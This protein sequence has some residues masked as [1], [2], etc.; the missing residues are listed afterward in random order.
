M[1]DELGFG[2]SRQLAEALVGFQD[3][4][5]KV[6]HADAEV[7][8]ERLTVGVEAAG[9]HAGLGYDGAFRAELALGGD[10][11]HDAEGREGQDQKGRGECIYHEQLDGD[12]R[13]NDHGS[14]NQRV[15]LCQQSERRD[16]TL[17]FLEKHTDA[18]TQIVADYI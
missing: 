12:R 11:R 4:P 18:P 17:Y 10:R 7:L 1:S 9:H 8:I 3:A 13:A 6:G 15:T 16:D 14:R 5:R 2:I